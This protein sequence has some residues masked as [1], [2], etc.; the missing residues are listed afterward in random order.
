MATADMATAGIGPD[1]ESSAAKCAGAH[2]GVQGTF[3]VDGY[4][5]TPNAP[6]RESLAHANR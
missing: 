2:C 6:S 5:E 4:I 1:M 3:A